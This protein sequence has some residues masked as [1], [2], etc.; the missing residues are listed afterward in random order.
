[1]KRA[2]IQLPATEIGSNPSVFETRDVLQLTG[3]PLPYLN[4]FIER[5]IF[6][7]GPS[8]RTGHG[9]GSRRLF[10]TNDVLGIALAWWLFRSGL[11]SRIISQTLRDL[12][13]RGDSHASRLDA[14]NNAAGV[15]LNKQIRDQQIQTL[16]ITR[17]L[18]TSKK[19]NES[20]EQ[21]VALQSI[22][23]IPATPDSSSVH[24]IPVGN[25]L[26]QLMA[27]IQSFRPQ[28]RP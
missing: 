16:V 26:E 15:L 8:I 21:T 3:I 24:S 25:L 23:R 1:M 22:S 19:R 6:G 2:S 13:P 20:S 9:R 27:K 5:G 17:Q 14:A 18:N 12:L 4:K 7:I 11:R 28:W 10:G